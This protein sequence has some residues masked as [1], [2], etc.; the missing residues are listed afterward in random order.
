MRLIVV[1]LLFAACAASPQDAEVARVRAHLEGAYA[2]VTSH[3]VSDLSSAQRVARAQVLADLRAYI[4]AEVYPTNL[5]SV[6]RTPIFV[7]PF[8]VR[9]AMAAVIEGSGHAD[10]V[11]RIARDH[12]YARIADLGEDVELARWLD[13][14]GVT[15]AEAARIQPAYSNAT[16]TSWT[17]TAGPVVTAEAGAR[18]GDVTDV[19]AW[20]LAGI[21]VGARRIT[22][23]LEGH[24]CDHCV[25]RSTAIVGEYQRR[26]APGGAG[27]NVVGLA[28]QH[29]LNDQ[30]RDHQ[31]YVFAGG[32]LEFGDGA[33]LGGKVGVGWSLRN[34]AA[35]GFAEVALV[36]QDQATGFSAHVGGAVGTV[37]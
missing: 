33:W 25:Y 5:V 4:D 23:T 28:W 35:P 31:V 13:E 15:L 1:V 7:D 12:L 10:L 34:R 32:A 20:L 2:E 37:W 8:G 6:D 16:G 11:Q 17:W 36:G 14:H 26:L 19:E 27:A 24:A 18:V 9:C 3:P 30:G 22:K 21:R 29:E